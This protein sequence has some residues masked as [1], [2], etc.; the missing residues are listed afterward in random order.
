MATLFAH[1]GSFVGCNPK[2]VFRT[3]HVLGR[4]K[5][6]ESEALTMRCLSKE[7]SLASSAQPGM[8]FTRHERALVW[9]SS[10]WRLDDGGQD[11]D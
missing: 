8:A 4:L 10:P 6:V 2:G 3:P 5:D 1:R 7:S 11:E 9:S